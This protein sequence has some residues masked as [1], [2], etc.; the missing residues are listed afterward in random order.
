[1]P[2]NPNTHEHVFGDTQVPP[3]TQDGEQMAE[4][5]KQIRLR[6]L[7]SKRLITIALNASITGSTGST[8]VS[9]WL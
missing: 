4:R 5:N 3:L 9:L 2:P 6:N 7:I 8:S 1:M